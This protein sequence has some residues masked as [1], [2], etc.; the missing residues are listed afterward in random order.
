MIDNKTKPEDTRY[1]YHDH[2]RCPECSG[3]LMWA[4]QDT[5]LINGARFTQRLQQCIR[6]AEFVGPVAYFPWAG[7]TITEEPTYM[8]GIPAGWDRD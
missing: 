4:K 3:E 1:L 7:V 6:C 2:G 8:G 5:V